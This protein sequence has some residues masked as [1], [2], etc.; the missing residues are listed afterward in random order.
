MDLISLQQLR[1]H[2]ANKFPSAIAELDKLVEL[3]VIEIQF[4]KMDQ[5]SRRSLVESMCNLRNIQVLKGAM[6]MLAH[7]KFS[8]S[9]LGLGRREDPVGLGLGYLPFLE[10]VILYLQ[11]SDASAVEVVEVEAMLRIEVHVHPNHPTL[12]LEEYHC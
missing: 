12:N 1:L 4:C 10:L 5:N 8:V 7:L 3:R 2:S 11:C 9:V 6:P